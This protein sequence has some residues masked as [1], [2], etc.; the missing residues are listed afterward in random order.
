MR[1]F[2]ELCGSHLFTHNEKVQVA[3][4]NTITILSCILASSPSPSGHNVKPTY[5]LF[6]FKIVTT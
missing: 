6:R 3:C 2:L 4:Y 5:L 1:L